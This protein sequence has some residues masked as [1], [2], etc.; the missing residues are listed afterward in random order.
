M[1]FSL[2]VLISSDCSLISGKKPSV[3]V[4]KKAGGFRH[5]N[6]MCC[7]LWLVLWLVAV[8]L[9]SCNKIQNLGDC[10]ARWQGL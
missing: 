4:M 6:K 5:S 8:T 7:V 3:D 1:S 2:R 10:A 9:S